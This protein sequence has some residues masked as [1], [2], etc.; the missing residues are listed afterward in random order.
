M[1]LLCVIPSEASSGEAIVALQMARCLARRDV[2]VRFLASAFAARLLDAPFPG[3]VT[4]FTPDARRNRDAWDHLLRTFDPGLVLFADYPLLFFS[5]GA[6]RLADES[7]CR[8]LERLDATLVTLDCLGYAQRPMRVCFGP[9]HLSLHSEQL[10]PIPD[11]MQILVPCPVQDPSAVPGRRG[12]PF[13]YWDLPM[14][15]AEDRRAE[16]RGRYLRDP[17]DVLVL[18][19]ASA[20]A[21]L[22][23]R[24]LRLPYYDVLPTLLEHYLADLPRPATIVSVN[25]GRLLPPP[26]DSK[27]RVLNV[28]TL[29]ADE[30][31]HL[32]LASDA[33]LTEN[34]V[35]VSLR[36]AVCGLTPCAVLRNTHGF[37]ELLDQVDAPLRRVIV[38]MEW[39]CP[40]SVFPYEVFPIWRRQDLE[41]LGLFHDDSAVEGF[42]SVEV[43]GG[44]ATRRLLHGLLTDEATR[45][46]W[47]ARQRAY[48]RRL[49]TLPGVYET[50]QRVAGTD[51]RNR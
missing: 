47:R 13:R 26:R 42:E 8:S 12:T 34:R 6:A 29:P 1:K 25:D 4:V 19:V 37:V 22:L 27:V 38:Q 49:Q 41:R 21:W 23:T 15:T 46:A 5:N 18:H 51:P 33:V 30:Y 11:R 10:P 32:M 39:S 35:S 3:R 14:R 40:G 36:R 24:H 48:V 17:Q 16:V 2:D 44:E 45:E 7:W 20:W 28:A 31:E 50:V 9:P 43:F